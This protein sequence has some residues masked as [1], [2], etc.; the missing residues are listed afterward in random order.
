MRLVGSHVI[1]VGY[2]GGQTQQLR[3]QSRILSLNEHREDL[4]KKV[5]PPRQ[6]IV[7]LLGGC[8][9]LLDGTFFRRWL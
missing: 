1:D 6:K 2:D 4:A 3:P 5:D 9:S 8:P 7:Q